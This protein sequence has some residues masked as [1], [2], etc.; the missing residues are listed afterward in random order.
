[1]DCDGIPK[2]VVYCGGPPKLGHVLV[3]PFIP[4]QLMFPLSFVVLRAIYLFRNTEG[5]GEE[6][7]FSFLYLLNNWKN[8]LKHDENAQ[9]IKQKG[10]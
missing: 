7:H 1:M 10:P 4:I 8:P 5:V 3:W 6:I 2:L 9:M